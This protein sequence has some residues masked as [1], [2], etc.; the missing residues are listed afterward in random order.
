RSAGLKNEWPRV[1]RP[2]LL[3]TESGLSITELDSVPGG[4]GLTAWLNQ[5]YSGLGMPV[6]G[7]ADGMLQGFAS[8]FAQAPTVHLVISE[9]SATYRPEMAW[10]ASQL[11]DARFKVQSPDFNHFKDGDAVYRFLELFDAENVPSSSLL[12]ELA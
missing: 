12:F 8:I 3:I 2:D 5:V 6:V 9:E 1:I 4:I 7:G 11:G 10:L